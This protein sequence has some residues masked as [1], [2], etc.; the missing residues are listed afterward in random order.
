M[1]IT[2]PLAVTQAL[3]RCPS[4]TP[5]DSGALDLVQSVLQSLD[6]DC[7]RLPFSGADSYPVDNLFAR[8][9]TTGPILGYGGHTDVVPVGVE[10]DW[11]VPPF[12]AGLVG[13]RLVGRGAV[14]M[15]GSI[16]AYIAALA[17]FLDRHPD[18]DGGMMLLITGDEE[19]DGINGTRRVLDWMD[20]HNHRMDHCL[21]GEPTSNRHLGDMIKIGRR[22]SVTFNLTING[23]Q[24][25]VAYPDLADNPIPAMVQMLALLTNEPLDSGTD[26]FLPSSLQVVTVDVGNPA[27][28]VIPGCVS[29]RFNVRF[30]DCYHSDQVVEWVKTRLNRVRTDYDLTWRVSGESFLCPPNRL[31]HLLEQAI[32]EVTGI[33]AELGTAGGTSDARFIRHHTTVAEFGLLN[34]TAHKVDESCTLGELEQLSD[35]YERLLEGYFCSGDKD[36]PSAPS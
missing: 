19:A 36:T 26:H 20:Q 8:R 4:V 34:S 16:G 6:F 13:D 11:S 2:N 29:A 27:S 5:E 3:I 35:I 25:H 17:R 24:G 1:E 33:T 32:T 14:D 7:T 18:F 31:S 12:S 10:G 9:G 15:K 23:V 22:G 21:V 30:N 28:N